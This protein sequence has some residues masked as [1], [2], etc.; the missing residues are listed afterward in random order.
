MSFT[1]IDRKIAI[2]LREEICAT[3]LYCGTAMKQKTARE[4]LFRNYGMSDTCA[5]KFLTKMHEMRIINKSHTGR[6]HRIK[7][8]RGRLIR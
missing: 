5:K 1:H 3:Y 8:I 4:W 7:G 2:D 6:L